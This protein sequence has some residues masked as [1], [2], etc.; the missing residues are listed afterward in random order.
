MI[1]R[2]HGASVIIKHAVRLKTG[3][4]DKSTLS[5]YTLNESML[6]I[7]TDAHVQS[8]LSNNTAFMLH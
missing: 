3:T 6:Y 5:R 1:G 8:T 2:R 4:R 7:G